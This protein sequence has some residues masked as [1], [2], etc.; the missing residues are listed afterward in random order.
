MLHF[1][2]SKDFFVNDTKTALLLRPCLILSGK[3]NQDI[4]RYNQTIVE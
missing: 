3:W 2:K 1:L 4:S